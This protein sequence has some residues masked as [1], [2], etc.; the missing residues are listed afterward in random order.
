MGA[1]GDDS[2]L[3]LRLTE[4]FP[5]RGDAYH[6]SA[7]C[8]IVSCG[9]LLEGR[10]EAARSAQTWARQ[11]DAAHSSAFG[12]AY[13]QALVAYSF[14]LQ[15]MLTARAQLE[16]IFLQAVTSSGSRSAPACVAA[17]FLAAAR[18]ESGDLEAVCE[19]IGG[20][21]LRRAGRTGGAGRRGAGLT[22][23]ARASDASGHPWDAED[24]LQRL[25]A[26]GERSACTRLSLVAAASGSD[27]VSLNSHSAISHSPSSAPNR[28]RSNALARWLIRLRR[29]AAV[30]RSRAMRC[31]YRA[32]GCSWPAARAR[33]PCHVC[34]S[35]WKNCRRAAGCCPPLKCAPCW[36]RPSRSRNVQP[37]RATNLP[38]SCT[39]L[40]PWARC[41]AWRT[42]GP[43][44]PPLVSAL[45]A[46]ANAEQSAWLARLRG[47]LPASAPDAAS[48]TRGFS[49]RELEIASLL[50]EGLPNKVIASSLGLAPDTIK[51]HL[52]NLYRK[53]GVSSRYHAIRQIRMCGLFSAER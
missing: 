20:S 2:A 33:R 3:C 17:A 24:A 43:C 23:Y 35:S 13:G 18:Y 7:A 53:L 48:S 52:K 9:Y 31:N 5:P 28:T 19:L 49:A 21:A 10:I 29:P 46:G 38:R 22:A 37:W 36:R 41:A 50:G 15:G 45:E 40:A 16:G 47:A 42:Q 11:W 25:R 26:H 12:V 39:A 27:C 6:V 44:W 4:F 8:N 32:R 51:W 30:P 34:T 14:L 1:Y